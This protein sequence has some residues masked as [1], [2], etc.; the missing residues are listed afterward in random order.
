MS[1]FLKKNV[2]YNF[3]QED[4]ANGGEGAP[5]NTYIS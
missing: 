5:L 2:I 4:I 1:Q 3:R